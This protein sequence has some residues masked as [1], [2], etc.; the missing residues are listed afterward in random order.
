[1]RFGMLVHAAMGPGT[2]K[3]ATN[4]SRELGLTARVP[5]PIV[6]A[7]DGRKTPKFVVWSFQLAKALLCRF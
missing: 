4:L 2:N 3:S 1:V 6:F 5:A 7:R